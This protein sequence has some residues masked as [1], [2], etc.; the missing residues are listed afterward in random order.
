ML[1]L[2]VYLICQDLLEDSCFQAGVSV[3]ECKRL[4]YSNNVDILA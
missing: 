4:F 2:I 1:L 3:V